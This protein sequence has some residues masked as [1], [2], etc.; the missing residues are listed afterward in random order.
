[1]R[2]WAQSVEASLKKRQ[3]IYIPRYIYRQIT[4]VV[5]EL[6]EVLSAYAV[7]RGEVDRVSSHNSFSKAV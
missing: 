6:W 5:K 1:M 7:P 2:G 4:R 3:A